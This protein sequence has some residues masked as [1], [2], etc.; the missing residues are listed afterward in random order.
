VNL[1]LYGEET[2]NTHRGKTITG[3]LLVMKT[4]IGGKPGFHEN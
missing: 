4:D 2:L 1:L 3:F